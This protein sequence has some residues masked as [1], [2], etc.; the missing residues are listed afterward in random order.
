[1]KIKLQFLLVLLLPVSAWSATWFV[2]P[3]VYD[4][5]DASGYPIVRAGVYGAQNGTNYGNAWNGLRSVVWGAGG[6]Q[7][8]DTLYVCGTHI[9]SFTND[10][11]LNLQASTGSQWGTTIRMDWSADPGVMFGGA[12]DNRPDTV[13]Y[14]P[15]TNGVYWSP[16]HGIQSAVQAPIL[17]EVDGTNITRL[18]TKTNTTWV[19]DLGSTAFIGNTNFVK[20]LTG[21]APS[22]NLALGGGGWTIWL[23]YFASNTNILF[24]NCHFIGR[25]PFVCSE[26]NKYI[27]FDQC[28]FM[29]GAGVDLYYGQDHWTFSNCEI[30]YTRCGIYTHI[31]GL[32]SGPNYLTVA[33]CYI[34]DCAT[35][36]YPDQ[37]GH[38]IGVQGSSFCLLTHN[39]IARTGAAIEF[40]TYN[41]PMSN[42]VICYNAIHDVHQCTVT[43]G[44]GIG[45]SG[46]N[47]AS[48]PGLRTGIQIFG[49]IIW[50][51]DG[52]GISS[53]NKDY[54][55]VFN[56]TIYNAAVGID[57]G[58]V[59][60]NAYG[61]VQNNLIAG[62]RSTYIL[63]IAGDAPS[64]N[65]LVVNYNLYAT[66]AVSKSVLVSTTLPHDANSIYAQSLFDST[67][68]TSVNNFRL[69]RDS[70]A[71]AAGTPVGMPQDFS[72]TLISTNRPPDIGAFEFIY[73]SSSLSPPRRLHV[74]D[75]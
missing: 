6:V 10:L 17:F 43:T 73:A 63:A 68:P 32:P 31:E 11:S 46:D 15:D 4:G 45:I 21:A 23:S 14:G 59:G 13:W 2:R 39:T 75:E 34:H 19:G 26:K 28:T 69:S 27:T 51:T 49:N 5:Q 72:G 70:K 24:Q 55:T 53:N 8:G 40:W 25:F 38:S 41:N 66:N 64:T 60:G 54:M 35:A 57:F 74:V 62:T 71:I 47:T 1:L 42:N 30:G 61:M 18:T 65:N 37:D 3:G 56:N 48:V 9:Y 12:I 33:N 20:T 50:N 67:P 7:S 16:Q 44:E 22:G 29:Q 36:N 58:I 52:H